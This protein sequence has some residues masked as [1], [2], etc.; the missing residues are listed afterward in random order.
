MDPKD[1]RGLLDMVGYQD[2]L[3]EMEPREQKDTRERRE[4]L[5]TLECL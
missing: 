5:V 3:V 1:Q 4:R 2:N